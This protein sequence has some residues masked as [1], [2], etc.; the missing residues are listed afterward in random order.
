M[1]TLPYGKGIF[2][3]TT[4]NSFSEVRGLVCT[5]VCCLRSTLNCCT[6]VGSPEA[7]W[8]GRYTDVR[9]S[10]G[11]S[12]HGASAIERPLPRS[13]FLSSRDIK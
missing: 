7:G 9:R 13:V 5:F 10:G 4:N 6:A 2:A 8:P 1:H 11:L 12:V 3:H